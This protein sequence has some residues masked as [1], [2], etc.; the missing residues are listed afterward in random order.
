MDAN[1]HTLF[2]GVNWR[3]QNVLLEDIDRI[4]VVRGSGGISGERM[5][6]TDHHIITNNSKES[7]GTLLPSRRQHNEGRRIPLRAGIG[8]NFNYRVYGW[9]GR[10]P[11]FHR[12]RQL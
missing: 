2:A 3:L 12:M 5:L 11:E 1:V 10:R 7:R 9:D 4:E 6:S 8:N